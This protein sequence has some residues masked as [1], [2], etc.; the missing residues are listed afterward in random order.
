MKRSLFLKFSLIAIGIIAWPLAGCEKNQ[1]Q[2]SPSAQATSQSGSQAAAPPGPTAPPPPIAP[3]VG[4]GPHPGVGGEMSQHPANRVMEQINQYRKRLEENPKDLEALIALGNANF[5]I[6]RF[7][8]AKELYQQALEIDPKN[9]LV[10]TDLASCYRN[11]GDVEQAFQ[12]LHRV[13]AI[14]PKHETALYNLGVILLNERRDAQGAIATWEKLLSVHPRVE[15][16]AELKKRI[17]ELKAQ[18]NSPK[19]K[20]P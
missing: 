20:S 17:E 12:E 4:P 18:P 15:Y 6:Q 14:D 11:L 7:D 2:S 8:K 3:P 13:L 1:G 16:A 19:G 5:D 10:R 9:V